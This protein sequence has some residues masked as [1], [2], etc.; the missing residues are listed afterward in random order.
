[1]SE[2][3]EIKTAIALMDSM[4]R[5]GED[6]SERSLAILTEAR[7]QLDALIKNGPARRAA[8]IERW[9]H[10]WSHKA[11]QDQAARI[12]ELED[13]LSWYEQTVR[14]FATATAQRA[15]QAEIALDSD[16]GKTARKALANQHK[17]GET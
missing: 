8:A 17:E 7:K 2:I 5:S 3:G 16:R 12:K 10:N 15:Y 9:S 14:E 4:I 6:H 1:M 11:I 13:A